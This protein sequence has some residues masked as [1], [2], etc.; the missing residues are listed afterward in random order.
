MCCV[1]ARWLY[2]SC[3]CGF[4]FF[5]SRRRHTSYWRDWSSDVCSSDLSANECV[6]TWIEKN[7][8]P[9]VYRIH[10]T[11]DPKRILDFEET[12]GGFG[13]SLGFAS[14]PVKQITMKADRREARRGGGRPATMYE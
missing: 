2:S 5:P 1:G 10:E 14:L 4:F 9:G 3:V 13:Y 11:P 7:A 6:A 8:I 12:A